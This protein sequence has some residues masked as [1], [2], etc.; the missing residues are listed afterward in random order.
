MIKVEGYK[1]FRGVMKIV[2]KRLGWDSYEVE[3]EW[4]YKPD[5]DCWYNG[6]SSYPASICE[7]ARDEDENC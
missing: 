6:G 4:L 5:T 7:V 2:P 3:G 1:A